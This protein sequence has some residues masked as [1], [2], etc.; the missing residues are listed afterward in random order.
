MAVTYTNDAVVITPISR[1]GKKHRALG[2]TTVKHVLMTTTQLVPTTEAGNNDGAPFTTESEGIIDSIRIEM[3]IKN[4][5]VNNIGGGQV[6]VNLLK[7]GVSI[8]GAGFIENGQAAVGA[9]LFAEGYAEFLPDIAIPYNQDDYFQMR[10]GLANQAG[11][12]V[13]QTSEFRIDLFCHEKP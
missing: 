5:A 9:V 1:A 12:A 3:D 11:C 8:L 2:Y 10:S 6:W 7:N 13:D 4:S